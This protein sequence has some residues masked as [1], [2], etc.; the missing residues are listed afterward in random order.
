[1]AD[2]SRHA[3]HRLARFAD[4]SGRPG[5]DMSHHIQRFWCSQKYGFEVAHHRSIFRLT[6]DA[7]LTI[8]RETRNFVNEMTMIR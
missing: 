8:I 5:L 4:H 3:G 2:N 6:L 7:H 1:M